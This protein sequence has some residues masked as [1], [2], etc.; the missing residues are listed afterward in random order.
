MQSVKIMKA[1]SLLER[2]YQAGDFAVNH[3]N[4]ALG[5]RV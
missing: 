4:L 5:Y 2:A 3:L 1:A